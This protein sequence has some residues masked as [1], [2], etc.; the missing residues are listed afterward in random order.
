VQSV[1]PG[2]SSTLIPKPQEETKE[3]K[4]KESKAENKPNP[5]VRSWR[6]CKKFFVERTRATWTDIIIAIFTVVIGGASIAQWREMSDAGTQTDKIIAADERL[7]I[8]MERSVAQA[9][10]AFAAANKQAILS[11]RAWISV[12][13]AAAIQPGA[14]RPPNPFILGQPFDVRITWK[15]T[16]RT[17]ALRVR[18]VTKRSG[19][20]AKDGHFG[21]PDFLYK[22]EDFQSLDNLMPD[23]EIYGDT[24]TGPLNEADIKQITSNQVHVFIYG[25][26]E[27]DDVFSVHHWRT[28][29]GQ[30]LPTGA[31]ALC[32]DHNEIDNNQ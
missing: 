22:P 14:G 21:T 20:V 12:K 3:S 4:P 25:R 32:P 18:S 15:N 5:F 10:T 27:Y 11:Q 8:A 29:C 1:Q 2:D 24:I 13:I 28:Y 16:G 26:I 30:L 23:A 9:E 7:A 19:F 6:R 31:I 17:P